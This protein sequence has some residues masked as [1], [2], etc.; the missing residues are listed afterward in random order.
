MTHLDTE[1]PNLLGPQSVPHYA[2]SYLGELSAGPAMAPTYLGP[3]VLLP[4]HSNCV[5][6]LHL[7]CGVRSFDKTQNKLLQYY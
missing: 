7:Y 6:R 4:L 2:H 5:S 3:F 1:S